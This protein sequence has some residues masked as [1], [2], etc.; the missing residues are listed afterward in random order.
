[1]SIAAATELSTPPLI[2]TAIVIGHSRFCSRLAGMLSSSF[3]TGTET[4]LCCLQSREL[5]TT[6]EQAAMPPLAVAVSTRMD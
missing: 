4:R 5:Y 3:A 1:L 6:R 2:A